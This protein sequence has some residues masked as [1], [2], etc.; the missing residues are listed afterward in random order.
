MNER[1]KEL[2]KQSTNPPWD[3]E[4]GPMNEFNLERF[5][6]LIV[7]E[8]IQIC[9]DTRKLVPMVPLKDD[10]QITAVV[11]MIKKHF[12]VEQ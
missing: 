12:G 10:E 8:C 1:I 2:L 11:C 4:Q 5:A 9:N 6:E 3:G 7:Q